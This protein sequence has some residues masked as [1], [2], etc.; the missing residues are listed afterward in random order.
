MKP[1]KKTPTSPAA[2]S[3]R[4]AIVLHA[5]SKRYEIHHEKPTL[6]EQFAKGRNETFWA[7]KN[8][9]LTIRK[10]EKVGIIGPNGSG[11]TTLLK[12][13]TGITTQTTGTV[14][15]NGKVVSLI[16]LEAGFHPDLTG[17]QNIYLNAM[18]LGM[19]KTEIDSK[20]KRIIQFADIGQFIDAPMF[21]YSAGMILRL[22]FAIAVHADPDVLILDEGMSIGDNSFHKK[23]MKM[24]DGY[25]RANK[26]IIVVSHWLDF[27]QDNCDTV[28]I[29][30]NGSIS[31]AGRPDQMIKK[32]RA[33]S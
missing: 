22:G 6:V 13:I 28:Y 18:I 19:K 11:K 9:H 14:T 30:K 2:D 29:I 24:I 7:L 23:A 10:G 33:M 5:V 3:S 25:F 27:I 26:T 8:I 17:E 16:D 15:T 32:Y 4:D 21:T 31:H 20:K 12:I 1:V